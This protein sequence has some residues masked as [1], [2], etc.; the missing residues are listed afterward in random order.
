MLT[1]RFFWCGEGR[2]ALHAAGVLACARLMGCLPGDVQQRVG[3]HN[4][5]MRGRH[6]ATDGL[7]TAAYVLRAHSIGS[8]LD[9]ANHT[10]FAS[11]GVLRACGTN[12]AGQVRN[13]G[14]G[15]PV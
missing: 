11:G 14:R 5:C 13:D 12:D 8:P 10:L 6:E 2:E 15:Q 3:A 9:A 7:R 1:T 4:H